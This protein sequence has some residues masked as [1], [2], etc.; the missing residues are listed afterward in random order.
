M[1]SVMEERKSNTCEVP[2]EHLQEPPP[3]SPHC[4]CSV[5]KSCQTLRSHGLQ[6]PRLACSSVSPRD[7]SNSC[8]LSWWCH[9][10]I[11]SF[12]SHFSL[13][14]SLSQH[15]SLFLWFSSSYQLS[16]YCSF[17]I[18]PSNEYSGLISLRI[19]WFGLL[20]VQGTQVSSP[21]SQFESISSSALSLFLWWNCH[22]HTELLEKS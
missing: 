21:A 22:I 20:F 11:W 5:T 13:A 3:A 1:L 6:H 18:S 17:S 7:C 14:L 16:K 8:P 9:P 4:G 12:V 19:D 10:S 15:Q 2:R